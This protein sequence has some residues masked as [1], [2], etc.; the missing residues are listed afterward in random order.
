VINDSVVAK[1]TGLALRDVAGIHALGGGAARALGVIRNAISSTDHSQGV[2]VQVG[3]GDVSVELSIVADYPVP[4][5]RVADDARAAVIE[6]IETLVGLDVTEVN[7]TI[8]DIHLPDD[9]TET[10]EVR[11]P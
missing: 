10:S 2:S 9:G 5:Q 11:A 1:I 3:D 8:N 7:V 6:A 4:L